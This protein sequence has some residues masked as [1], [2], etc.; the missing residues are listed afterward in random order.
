MVDLHLET[1]LTESRKQVTVLFEVLGKDHFGQHHLCRTAIRGTK[2]EF[3]GQLPSDGTIFLAVETLIQ[4]DN[5]SI[6][7]QI[8]DEGRV[9][10]RTQVQ[11][12]NALKVI[13]TCSGI[14]CLGNGLEQA[15][16]QI[17]L[18]HDVNHILLHLANRVFPGPTLQG[19]ICSNESIHGICQ[20]IP[21]S[22]S[23]AAGVSCQPHSKLGDK[24]GHHDPRSA[25]LPMTLRMCFLTRQMFIILECVEE[26]I[27]SEWAQKVLRDFCN[28]T[29]YKMKQGSLHLHHVWVSRRSRW[30]CIL[31]HP[32][33]STIEW[34]PFP[35]FNPPPIVADVLDQ[36]KSCN[37][38]ELKQLQL[39]SYE[40]GKFGVEGITNNLVPWR[41]QA[42]TCLHSCG[43]QVTGCPCGCR[44]F[45]FNEDRLQNGGIHG[46]I[47]QTTQIIQ[48]INGP[49]QMCRHIA[50]SELALINGVA[51]TRDFGQDAKLALCAIG[52]LASPLQ[53][54]WIGAHIMK[55][56]KSKGW[57]Q[58]DV[59][60]PKALL[61]QVLENVLKERDV[62]FGVPEKPNTSNFRRILRAHLLGKKLI[63]SH[64]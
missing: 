15:G 17:V 51:P 1:P 42:K 38:E 19:D 50:P 61:C 37:D 13:E 6:L 16:F 44:R 2:F 31:S 3:Q 64:P 36:F 4:V 26:I 39:D 52:Q 11:I 49:M 7:M 5:G 33:F 53:S 34:D 10:D 40:M 57:V 12:Q 23:V 63:S 30:W 24:R 41:G 59:L 28:T 60:S 62:Y 8:G 22:C 45:P 46:H 18:K 55:Y 9:Y 35:V 47:V 21:Y 54:A 58:Q 27:N 48:T 25:T 32:M 29:G 20:K 43:N 14:G 56:M